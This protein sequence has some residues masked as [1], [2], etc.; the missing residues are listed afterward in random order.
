LADILAE[1]C[2]KKRAEIAAR[3]LARSEAE[4]ARDARMAP[5][6]RGFAAS[7]LAAA[8][9]R[10]YGLICEIKKASP[11]GGLIR[12]DFRPAALARA[13]EKGGATCLSVLTDA[14]YFQGEDSHLVAARGA[15]RLPVLRKDFMLD[16]Y[17]IIES[18][19]LGADCVLLILACLDDELAHELDAVA[20]QYGMDVLLEVHD[21]AE[22]ERAIKLASPLIGINNR[23]LK[24]LETDLGTTRRLAPRVPRDRVAVCESGLKTAS[25]LAAMAE[26]GARAFL[27]GESLMR[28]ADVEAAT[29]NFLMVRDGR[30]AASSP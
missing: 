19:A 18:R 23:N 20:H 11:S 30:F 5:P 1:I 10:G 15:C 22:L 16:P 8:E 6:P 2:A 24:T 9:A 26:C 3:R 27:I 14:P 28:Q 25:D 13:Y 12:P 7:L 17:Q 21:E 4:V 29:R